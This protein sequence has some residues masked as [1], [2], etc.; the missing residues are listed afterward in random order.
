MTSQSIT[1]QEIV[2]VRS[3]NLVA[4]TLATGVSP[5]LTVLRLSL[6]LVM[7]PHGAQ[8]LLGWFG[9]YGFSGTMGFLTGPI[10]LPWLLGLAV[11]VIEFFAPLLLAVGLGTRLAAAGIVAIM[12]GAIVTV[13]APNGFFM[14]W[15]GQQAG[16]GFEY[17]ILA[18]GMAL[19]LLL[20]GGGRWS[21]DRALT[22]PDAH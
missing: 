3:A 11:I 22:A 9:G 1:Y 7:L 4:R 2:P 6:A 8:K 17:H 16:E 19:A 15:S 13:H 10:G 5:S 14:N 18:I 12:L 21:L 20:A